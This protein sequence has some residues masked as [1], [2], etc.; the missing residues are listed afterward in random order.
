MIQLWLKRNFFYIYILC[1]VSTWIYY[2]NTIKYYQ[3]LYNFNTLYISNLTI[4][5]K[6]YIILK[7]YTLHSSKYVVYWPA[8]WSL[9]KHWIWLLAVVVL[10]VCLPNK[11]HFEIKFNCSI[12]FFASVI[13]DRKCSPWTKCCLQRTDPTIAP[14]QSLTNYHILRESPST[15]NKHKVQ[16]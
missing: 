12:G 7:F 14:P 6:K 13:N 16:K 3:M 4:S 1:D 10:T 8:V 5:N 11:V 15:W 9:V 2:Q